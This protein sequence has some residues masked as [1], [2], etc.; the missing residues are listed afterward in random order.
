MPQTVLLSG[1]IFHVSELL[2]ILTVTKN[3]IVMSVK[4]DY[5]YN[6]SIEDV[7]IQIIIVLTMYKAT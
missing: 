7:Y 1:F 6:I 3:G 2:R 4:Q 5:V